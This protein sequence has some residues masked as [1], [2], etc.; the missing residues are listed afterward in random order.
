MDIRSHH[1]SLWT[2]EQKPGLVGVGGGWLGLLQHSQVDD[3]MESH[4]PCS[5]ALCACLCHS[6]AV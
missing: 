5:P 3:N 6:S 1:V 2:V 4:T